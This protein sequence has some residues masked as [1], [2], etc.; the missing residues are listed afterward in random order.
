MSTCV[1]NKE[2][3]LPLL[4]KKSYICKQQEPHS[5]DLK[6]VDK[7]VYTWLIS[8]QS[9][10]IPIEGIIPK[11]KALEFTKALGEKSLKASN[12][13]LKNLNKKR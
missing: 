8:K 13:W 10:Q 4:E 5:R 12:C 11:E 1:K 9:K 2:Q 7:A 6:R 3:L